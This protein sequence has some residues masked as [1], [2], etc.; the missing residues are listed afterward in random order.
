VSRLPFELLLALRYLRPKRTF[1]SIITLISVLGVTLGVAVLI[2]VISVMSGFD[3]QLRNKVL[4]FTAH[5]QITQVDPKTRRQVLLDSFARVK[6]IVEKNPEVQ[7]VA[8]FA[9]GQVM[10]KTEPRPGEGPPVIAAPYLRG[11]DPQFEN[12]SSLFISNVVDG[13]ADLDGR[14]VLIGVDFAHNNG[15]NI[16]DR[17]SV[18]SE[19]DIEKMQDMVEHPNRTNQVAYLPEDYEVHGI[20]DAGYW[21]YNISMMITSLDNFQ[22][23]YDLGDTVHGA[24]VMIK[25]PYQASTVRDQLTAALGSRYRITTWD[26]ENSAMLAVLVEKNV[27]FYI[28]FFIVIVAAFGIT[29]TLITFVVLKT[30]EIG[31]LKALGATGRGIMW[32]FM[33]QSL[34][35]SVLGVLVGTAFGMVAILYRNPFLHFMRNVTHIDLF[36]PNIYEFNELPAL[37]VPGDIAIICGGSLLIC[38]LAAAFPAWNASRLKPVEAL[39]HE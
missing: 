22:E 30:R 36:P 28:L 32:I 9:Q 12:Q 31:V 10:I 7:S 19:R 8:P 29:C 13:K 1:V 35:V 20:F 16:G 37:I 33:S 5:I 23:L 15:L 39:R 25:N 6:S 24:M 18:Y 4:G 11:I 2:I 27:M 38:L 14:S 26:E 21:D 34:V 17:M 3:S